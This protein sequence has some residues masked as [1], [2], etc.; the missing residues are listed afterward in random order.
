MKKSLLA[1]TALLTLVLST[2][3]SAQGPRY[4]FNRNNTPGWSLMTPEE[5]AEHRNRML[6]ARTYEECR[7]IQEEHRKAMEA[8]AK[9]KGITL[10]TPRYNACERMKAR[11]FFKEQ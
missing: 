2:A 6:A 5:R 7:Q 8:R 10:G 4:Q 9:E 1:A 11:G 3:A